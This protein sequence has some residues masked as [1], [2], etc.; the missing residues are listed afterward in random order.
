MRKILSICLVIV[1]VLLSG[2]NCY[3][4]MMKKAIPGVTVSCSPEVLV[5]KG[6]EVTATVSVKFPAK[7]FHPYGVLK[8][9]PV[10]TFDG[11]EVV[12]EP[13]FLQGDK[14]KDNY[15][16]ISNTL[17]G[18]YQQ[19]VTFN[20]K[21][22]MRMSQLV[23]RV[24]AKCLKQGPKIKNFTE[25]NT[26]IPVASGINTIKLM[27][28]NYAECALI[29][30]AFK[31]TTSIK[32]SAS[33]MFEINKADVRKSQLNSAELAALENF[34]KTNS[35]DP[36]KSVGQVY[37]QAYASPDGPLAL[38]DK[39]SKERGTQTKKAV[40]D[41]FKKTGIASETFDV[42]A[43][44]EDWEG[45]KELVSKSDIPDKDIILQVLSM[46]TDPQ[47]RDRE[48]RNMSAAFTVLKEKILPEL[49]RSK[50]TVNVD[51][52]GL[53][54]DEIKAAISSNI[55][56]LSLE[57]MLFAATLYKDNVTKEKCYQAAV[58]KY[59]DY[60]A[61]NN[62]GYV[63]AAEGRYPQAKACFEKAASLNNSNPSIINNLGVV[64]L[65]Q[66]N[67]ADAAK[68]FAASSAPEA[69][70]NKALVDLAN[71]N[72][73]AIQALT[74]YNKA[75]GQYL[76]GDVAGAKNTLAP[77]NNWEAC[78]LK[79]VIAAKEGNQSAVIDNLQ[80]SVKLHPQAAVTAYDDINFRE[81]FGK[82]E[83]V[84]LVKSA[85]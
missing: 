14:V 81:Y 41:K 1:T 30:D 76:S 64:A 9:T 22:E 72:Y 78:Y 36:K 24:E 53:S 82:P 43:M 46:Y 8:I 74:G 23:L 55:N 51:V 13:K 27:A 19:T 15:T 3:D 16:I 45:F 17:G 71:G 56:S 49:R 58:D 67:N 47:V 79:A 25:Y 10:L 63:H 61:W 37:T 4:S 84:S 39:L 85:E 77:L 12:G 70:Y 6:D 50:M 2:C 54:D 60:R 28:D 26:E 48:I 57:E 38:N 7:A 31:R 83:F 66:G 42:N 20:Y 75:L 32:E 59:N 18:S 21:P 69:K 33:V 73:S 35:N 44:G 52:E 34:I 29:P 68:Y 11:G 65:A 5:L 80:K 40:S 62:L